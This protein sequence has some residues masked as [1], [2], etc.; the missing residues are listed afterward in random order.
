[1]TPLAVPRRLVVPLLSSILMAF[2]LVLVP[3]SPASALVTQGIAGHV[4]GPGGTALSGIEVAF[5]IDAGDGT[6][7]YYDSV[8]TD[9]LGNYAQSLPA[10]TWRVAFA[11]S[12]NGSYIT[13]FYDNVSTLEAAT[14]LTV[15]ASHVTANINAQL[16]AAGHITGHVAGGTSGTVSAWTE[17]TPGAADWSP[18]AFADVSAA[19]DY[20]LGGLATGSYRVRF[21]VDGFAPEYWQDKADLASATPIAV[22]A[23]NSVTGINPTLTPVGHVTGHVQ[24]SNGSPIPNAWI[25]AYTFDGTDW[26]YA[27]NAWGFTDASGDYDLSAPP[28]AYRLQFSADGFV[29]EYYDNVSSVA[30]ATSITVDSGVTVSGKNVELATGASISGQVTLPA[31]ADPTGDDGAV[32]AVDTTTGDVVGQTWIDPTAVSADTYAYTLGGLPAGSYRVE[33]AHEEGWVTSEAEFYNDHP[34]SA[35]PGSA[36]A[37]TLTTGQQKASVDATLRAGGTISGTL[38]DGNGDPVAGCDVVAFNNVDHFASRIGTSAA[39]G[40]FSVTG[41]TTG[42]YGLLV[43]DPYQQGTACAKTE[44]YTNANGDLSESSTGIVPVSSKPG[45][46][47]PLPAPLVY[48]GSVATPSVTNAAAPTVPATAPV[49]G[50]PVNANPGTWDPADATLTYQWK[51]NGTAIAGATQASYTPVQG[52]VGKALSVDVTGSKSGYTAATATSNSTAPV[53]GASQ[54]AAIE[55]TATPGISGIAQVGEQLSAYAG[56]WYT[57]A[58]APATSLQWLRNGVPIVGA[59]GS[60]YQL[61]AD[62][63]ATRISLRVTATK[64]GYQPSQQTSEPTAPVAAGIL[65]LIDVPRLLGVL[66]VGKVLKAVAPAS[67][68]AATTVR[69]QWLRNGVAIKG[70]R[71]KQARYS[72][73][74]A[75]RGKHISVRITVLRPGYAPTPSVAKKPGRVK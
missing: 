74:R 60:T 71:A 41:L 64:D 53:T 57:T 73:V 26:V 33:F 66:K 70:L 49:V 25:D 44:Y 62:D 56:S 12:T 27:E 32:A 30:D 31:G 37:V 4:T 10:S 23:P 67:T 34:E 6:F 28:G 63:L 51:A 36:D 55:N 65:T 59:T 35:G 75:D 58:G 24:D 18:Y 2:A 14:T 15:T 42:Q 20:D 50:T 17:S 46:D 1:M 52:D 43:G 22:T 45:S 5:F 11:D 7:G 38:L 13:E 40:T 54:S 3:S 72:L 16:A 9:A 29:S 39:D 48:G 68:P 61:G 47:T 69:Y 19:G 21:D 8:A